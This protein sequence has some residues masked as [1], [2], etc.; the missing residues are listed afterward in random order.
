MGLE[1]RGLQGTGR[2]GNLGIS[3]AV[4]LEAL[5]LLGVGGLLGN[6]GKWSVPTHR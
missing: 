2:L 6:H 3:G 1:S 4:V 5:G